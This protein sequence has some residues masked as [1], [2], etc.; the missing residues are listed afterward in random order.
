ME[1]ESEKDLSA[2]LKAGALLPL[3]LLYGQ[4]GYLIDAYAGRIT[5]P[6]E[7]AAMS[8]FNFLRFDGR[9]GVDVDAL[10]DAC[11]ALPLM[12]ARKCVV[13]EGLDPEKLSANDTAKLEQLLADP[14]QSCLL[15]ITVKSSLS[16]KDKK[17]KGAKLV[18]LC[19]KAGA[20]AR[21]DRRSRGDVAKFLR[22]QAAKRGCEMDA[23]VAGALLERCGMDMQLLTAEVEKLC[24]YAGGG[25]LTVVQVRKVA[26]VNL[27][28]SIFDLSNAIL[29]R[30][31][32][33]AM[34][35]VADLIFLRESPVT[36]LSALSMSFV[37]IYRAKQAKKARISPAQAMKEL[38]Y[39]GGATYRFQ[40]ASGQADRFGDAFLAEALACLAEADLKLKS[41]RADDRT[42]LEEAITTLFL[43]MQ[44]FV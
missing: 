27:E 41:S 17:G 10:A 21:L 2:H 5:A 7:K 32:Q 22:E 20:A 11:E 38:G 39:F 8:E 29:K 44:Q 33:N 42:V 35:V 13:L 15:L 12:A 40:K 37:D 9:D 36:I 25:K 4:E 24:A 19:A 1:F 18:T 6:F 16:P 34:E 28:A 43:L 23:E 14:P 31:Y 26:S 3:Y 30:D